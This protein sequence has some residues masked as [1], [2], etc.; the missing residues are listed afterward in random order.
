MP[1]IEEICDQYTEQGYA[2]P[3]RVLAPRECQGFL[4][5]IYDAHNR[6]PLDWPKGNAINSR[7]FYEISVHPTILEVVTALLGEDV[8]LWGAAM[9]KR[10]PG[11]VLPWHSDV[12]TSAPSGRT[13]SVWLGIKHTGRD[14]SL[15]LMPYSHRFGVT[16]QELRHRHGKD[17]DATTNDDIVGWAQ[18]RDKRSHMMNPEVT[19]GE[20]LFFDGRLWHGSHNLF[21]ET[22]WALLLQYATPDTVIRIPD[23]N[24]LDWPFYQFAQP[25]PACLLVR[26]SA[27]VS[28]NRL[29]SAPVAAS[30]GTNLQLTSLVHSFRLPLPPEEPKGRKVYSLFHGCT[31]NLRLLS[32]R[33]SVLA[34]NQNPHPPH[35]HKEEEI[36]L[37]L[38]GEVDIIIPGSQP[39]EKEQRKRLHPGQFVYQPAHCTHTLQAM[40]DTPATYL[41]LKWNN[42]ST[43]TDTALAFGHFHPFNPEENAEVKTGFSPRLVLE[44]P[45]A[46]LRKLHCHAS[47]LTPG[48]SYESHIDSHDVAIIVLEGEV[49]TLGERVGPYSVIFYPAGEPHGMRNP[50]E[51]TA[52]YVVFEFHGRQKALADALSHYHP[53]LFAKLIDPQCWQRTWAHFYKK[54]VRRVGVLK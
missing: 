16:V 11:D 31:A 54:A 19:D 33:E 12:E 51:V 44:G 14:S 37:L 50:G 21:R 6:P 13:V 42:P 40:S 47:T 4:Q 10:P 24:N 27:K 2:G 46:Y 36:L 52:K 20:A 28:V 23:P 25:R 41:V 45:T 3:V 53:S 7:V 38:A 15:L 5:A 18:E 9:R 1:T 34:P 29:V 22:R 43:E 49:E 26:G 48:T 8:M 39:D 35:E 30:G 32:C 17:Q